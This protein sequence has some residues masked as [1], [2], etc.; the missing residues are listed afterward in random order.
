LVEGQKVER[1]YKKGDKKMM[2]MEVIFIYPGFLLYRLCYSM[3][4]A[5][6]YN[7]PGI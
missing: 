2:N 3:V 1:L 7:H 4:P 5:I 6:F